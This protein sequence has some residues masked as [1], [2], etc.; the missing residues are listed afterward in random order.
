MNNEE[1]ILKS[2]ETI[3]GLIPRFITEWQKTET[4][5]DRYFK[6]LI[7]GDNSNENND[8]VSINSN[9]DR[10]SSE[11]YIS[12][13]RDS[14]IFEVKIKINWKTENDYVYLISKIHYKVH[15]GGIFWKESISDSHSLRD[16]GRLK[17]SNSI[18]WKNVRE[19]SE[20]EQE[21]LKGLIATDDLTNYYDAIIAIKSKYCGVYSWITEQYYDNRCTNLEKGQFG[22]D[23]NGKFYFSNEFPSLTLSIKDNSADIEFKG[24]LKNISKDSLKV[25]KRRISVAKKHRIQ[26]FRVVMVK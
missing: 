5:I 21:L 10:M 6:S 13:N 25:I 18:V 7:D 9:Q 26:L 11:I 12:Y 1:S 23:D 15:K 2:K 14:N 4:A 3:V 19:Y 16:S 22:I 20:E 24:Q 8:S 17:L